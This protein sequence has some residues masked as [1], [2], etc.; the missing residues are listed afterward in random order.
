MANAWKKLKSWFKH[1]IPHPR[2]TMIFIVIIMFLI[3]KLIM[4]YIDQTMTV[5]YEEEDLLYYE[6]PYYLEVNEFLYE[7]QEPR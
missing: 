2:E 5:P 6:D 1:Q 4:L 7:G 3:G